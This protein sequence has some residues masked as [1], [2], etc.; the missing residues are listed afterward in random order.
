MVD[1]IL[2]ALV[3]YLI[4]AFVTALYGV[5][6]LLIANSD[7]RIDREGRAIGRRLVAGC[8]VWPLLLAVTLEDRWNR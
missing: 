4:G 3:V 8:A 7:D 1:L 2:L 6:L 5:L